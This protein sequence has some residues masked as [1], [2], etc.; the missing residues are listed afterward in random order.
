[1]AKEIKWTQDAVITFEKVVTYL[2]ES[3]SAKEIAHFIEATEK[4]LHLIPE[5]PKMFRRS[6]KSKTHEA[7]IT[8]H[9]LLLYRVKVSRIELITFWDTRQNPRKKKLRLLK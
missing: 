6:K 3:W 9:N 1:M 4:M 5:N 8:K 7:L 2:Q